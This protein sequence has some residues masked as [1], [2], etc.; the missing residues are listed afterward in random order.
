M[1]SW[2]NLSVDS[3]PP[4]ENH[5][6]SITIV[7][8]PIWLWIYHIKKYLEYKAIIS[9]SWSP[10]THGPLANVL[11]CLL[12]NVALCTDTKLLVLGR[13]SNA[14][15]NIF[16]FYRNYLKKNKQIQSQKKKVTLGTSSKRKISMASRPLLM[17][18]ILTGTL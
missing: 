10:D 8:G 14:Y 3:G 1:G 18:L 16:N 11:L 17:S 4:S 12:V 9:Y 7:Q 5:C 6:V 15:V 13:S 2:P